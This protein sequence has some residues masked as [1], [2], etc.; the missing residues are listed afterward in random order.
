MIYFSNQ[1]P[2]KYPGP[3]VPHDELNNRFLVIFNIDTNTRYCVLKL[4]SNLI[5]IPILGRFFMSSG[6]DGANGEFIF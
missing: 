3:E 6:P 4:F 5:D 2:Y 1:G